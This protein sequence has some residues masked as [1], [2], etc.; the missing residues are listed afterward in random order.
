MSDSTND[1]LKQEEKTVD[2][3][4]LLAELRF[5]TKNFNSN[6]NDA[7][8]EEL[9]GRVLEI[10]AASKDYEKI[11][12]ALIILDEYAQ[13]SKKES[14]FK[15]LIEIFETISDLYEKGLIEQAD[16]L[17][18]GENVYKYHNYICE[19]NPSKYNLTTRIIHLS[20]FSLFYFEHDEIENAAFIANQKFKKCEDL[21]NEMDS[22]EKDPYYHLT[23]LQL[24]FIKLETAS[25]SQEERFTCLDKIV[26]H[27]FH[28]NLEQPDDYFLTTLAEYAIEFITQKTSHPK[29]EAERFKAIIKLLEDNPTED[30]AT[31]QRKLSKLKRLY[32]L[33]F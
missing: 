17:Q 3:D 1:K 13:H 5:F 18:N 9:A 24:Q 8:A 2:L 15:K 4:F 10:L 30:N 28:I 6:P 14:Y 25:L 22:T 11:R 32:I 31:Y 29:E 19:I 16:Y 26:N 21:F 27:L 33:H 7:L 12:S 20:G 23:G